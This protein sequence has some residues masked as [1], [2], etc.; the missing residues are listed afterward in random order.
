M[1]RLALIATV[2]LL[3]F[4]AGRAQGQQSGCPGPRPDPLEPAIEHDRWRTAPRDLF[5]EYRAYVASFDG[6]DDNDGD[7][8]SDLWRIPEWISYEL[9]RAPSQNP[10]EDRPRPWHTDVSLAA[11]S[12]AACDASYTG[13]GF[14]RGHL[15]MREHAR[16]SGQDADWNSHSILN[17]CP[18]L[19]E[20]NAGHWLS[21][22]KLCGLWA[23]H[24]DRIWVIC[25]PIVRDDAGNPQPEEL[26][27]D[28]GELPVVVPQGFF[29]I[30]VKES[31]TPNR[32]DV[33]AFVFPHDPALDN[34]SVNVDHSEFLV[35]VR[36]VEAQTG[37]DF[38]SDL[39]QA[40]Q[41]ALETEPATEV[42]GVDDPDFAA[43]WLAPDAIPEEP[44]LSLAAMEA[45][46]ALDLASEADLPSPQTP[47]WIGPVIGPGDSSGYCYP[48]TWETGFRAPDCC[49][50]CCRRCGWVCRRCRR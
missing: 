5:R 33:L 18:Q 46:I 44:G 28:A 27:G 26:I 10:F 35:S 1:R 20:F 15:C 42:W 48:G 9:R 43:R 14:D 40:D 30:V 47:P 34:A 31:T 36:D 24:F 37:L 17:A 22:E 7:G 4:A 16:R 12:I 29:K 19:H 3:G 38:F 23:N 21:L 41:D 50:P 13:S 11:Q 8:D 32:P 45:A 6:R 2:V 25:G 39:N 49:E